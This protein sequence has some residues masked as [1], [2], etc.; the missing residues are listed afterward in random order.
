M[1]LRTGWAWVAHAFLNAVAGASLL[2]ASPAA[3]RA[4]APERS[5][6]EPRPAI[7]LLEDEDTRIYLFGTVH[8]LPSDYRWRSPALDRVI[9]E[10][11]ELVMETADEVGD[12]AFGESMFLPKEVPILARVSAPYRARLQEVIAVSGL[13]I[14]MWNGLQTWAAGF[15]VMAVQ[16]MALGEDGRAAGTPAVTGAETVLTE[17]FRRAGKPIS[18][19]ETSEMQMDFFR[20]LSR[21]AQ[22]DF[23]ESVLEGGPPG[24]S[25]G[26]QGDDDWVAGNVEAIARDMDQFTPELYE[27]LL[28]RR[29][30]AWTEWLAARLDRPGTVL[31]AV[32]AGHLA[33]RDS[34]QTMLASRGLTTRRID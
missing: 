18:A 25:G 32:G 16:S 23:L 24:K 5:A 28:T 30:R 3:A 11:D 4:P 15:M 33:G 1:R 19:V 31:F 12:E 20:S 9:R 26:V 7:W 6:I 8:V 34:V 17:E 27:V 29:N 22:R 10:A 2:A 21:A 13:P 14:E